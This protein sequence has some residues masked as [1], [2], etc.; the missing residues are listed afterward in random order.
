MRTGNSNGSRAKQQPPRN[1][2]G[3]NIPHLAS[4]LFGTPLLMDE[5]KI[6]VI[7]PLFIDRINGGEIPKQGLNGGDYREPGEYSIDVS[8]GIANVPIIGSIV[9]RKTWLDAY[10][11]LTSY[12]DI[13]TSFDAAISDLRVKAILI[14]VDSF[15]GEAGDCFELADYIRSAREVKPIWAVSDIDALSAGY[16]LLSSASRCVVAARGSVGSIGAVCIH[17]EREKQNEAMGVTYTVLRSAPQKADA[18]PFERLPPQAAA[19]FLNS[20]S[21]TG[22]AFAELVNRN[23]PAISVADALATQGQWYDAEDGIALNLVDGVL[24]YEDV[25]AELAEFVSPSA[26]PEPPPEPPAPIEETEPADDPPTEESAMA[27]LPGNPVPPVPPVA[28]ASAT[29]PAPPA[30]PATGADVVPIASAQT[31][32]A[33]AFA[34]YADELNQTCTLAGRPDKF[35][36]LLAARISVSDA[37][38]RLIDE[39]A[40]ASA[41]AA[42]G[43]DVSNLNPNANRAG[44]MTGNFAGVNMTIDPGSPMSADQSKGWEKAFS[45]ARGHWKNPAAE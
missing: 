45:H 21:R 11:G 40:T 34:A 9:R 5:R 27:T 36:E 16:A 29:P 22:Q 15:G 8:T 19:R 2:S 28:G 7:A 1:G 32:D 3:G 42:G 24:T 30:P 17:V 38:K 18:T 39:R 12:S 31:T 43:G 20:L 25:F 35:G 44:V 37:R 23:R 13:R 10:S 41:A 6:D 26:R 14:H 4:R 33:A